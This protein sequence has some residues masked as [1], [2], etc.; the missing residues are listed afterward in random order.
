MTR[1][2]ININSRILT[3]PVLIPNTP[4]CTYNQGEPVLSE[5]K[6]RKLATSFN[7]YGIIDYEHQFNKKDTEGYQK[8]VGSVID[9]W[10]IPEEETIKGLDGVTRTYP[11]GTW[12]LSTRITDPKV[13]KEFDTG[14]IK[15]FSST[16]VNKQFADNV[17]TKSKTLIKDIKNPV[18][19]TVSVTAS[20][21]VGGA[22]F[23]KVAYKHE[24]INEKD[25]ME[26]ET[27][28]K[29]IGNFFL[30]LTEEE[31]AANKS[32]EPEEKEE[33]K[34]Q[35]QKPE[36]TEENKKGVEEETANKADDT[37]KK[38]NPQ[39]NSQD[40]QDNGSVSKEDFTALQDRVSALEKQIQT[41]LDK[42]SNSS[43]NT[44][45]EDNQN[46]KTANK[47]KQLDVPDIN[48]THSGSISS[49]N[50]VYK[51]MGRT[52]YGRIKQ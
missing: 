8:Q 34:E 10:L 46:N 35:E 47:S 9:S 19:M 37:T 38:D 27:V 43:D 2:P 50:A 12:F 18:V 52:K 1:I 42:S 33:V 39:D 20:P 31:V 14:K 4:D 26:N 24:Q 23:C 7:N 45:K 40:N 29:K 15:G 22:K 21:C 3:A 51:A 5:D 49:T 13:I 32:E 16:T 25:N 30:N 41:L 11:K 36:N 17:A 48:S 44:Q 6:V 28:F